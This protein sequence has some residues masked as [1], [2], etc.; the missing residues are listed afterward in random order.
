[1]REFAINEV[2]NVSDKHVQIREK[3]NGDKYIIFEDRDNDDVI[4]L[5]DK[6]AYSLYLQLKRIYDIPTLR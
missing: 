3:P 4:P 6:D 2:G 1:M 5:K